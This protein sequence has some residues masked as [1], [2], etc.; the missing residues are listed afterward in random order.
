MEWR[1]ARVG[2]E[3]GLR[4]AEHRRETGERENGEKQENRR[5]GEQ[6]NRTGEGE[7]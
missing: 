6:E 4:H 7:A 2:Y 3:G 5:T 1:D